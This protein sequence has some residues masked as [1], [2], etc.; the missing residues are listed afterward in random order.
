MLKH[1]KSLE[2]SDIPSWEVSY[3][4]IFPYNPIRCVEICSIP[5]LICL[6]ALK[7]SFVTINLP[8]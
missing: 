7:V 3:L 8:K 6:F 1:T 5:T 4:G 2:I